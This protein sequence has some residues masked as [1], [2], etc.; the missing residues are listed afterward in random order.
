MLGMIRISE[1]TMYSNASFSIIILVF[2]LLVGCD[3]EHF[4][5]NCIGEC[6]CS[7]ECNTDTGECQLGECT[8]GWLDY[9]RCQT[10]WD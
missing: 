4:G 5:S 9:P 3:S 2:A 1:H 7:G 6:H 8:A 10:G